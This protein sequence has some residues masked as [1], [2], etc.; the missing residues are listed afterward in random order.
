M[1]LSKNSFGEPGMVHGNLYDRF[2]V[3]WMVN[4]EDAG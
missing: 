3:Y 2:G 4:V 1:F